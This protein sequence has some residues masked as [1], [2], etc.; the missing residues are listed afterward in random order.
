M[1]GTAVG[2]FIM[3][4][5]ISSYILNSFRFPFL[6]SLSKSFQKY[7]FNN[8]IIPTVFVAVYLFEIIYFQYFSQFKSILE[9]SINIFGFLSGIAM[10]ITFTLRY[11]LLTNKDIYKLFGVEHADALHLKEAEVEFKKPKPRR[12]KK[13]QNLKIWRVDTYMVMPFQ[14]R[15]VRSTEHYKEYMLQ[16]VFKQNH[17]NAA[18]M[19]L[20]VFSVFILLGLFREYGIFQIPA[21]ASLLLLFTI[22]IMLSG[23]FRFWLKS[24]ASTAII[25][26][27]LVL[28]YF[29]QFE[30]FNQ[31][32]KAIGL[33]YSP[34]KKEYTFTSLE[35]A[36]DP[37]LVVK[38]KRNTIAIL[39][40][41]KQKWQEK[42]VDKPK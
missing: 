2:V 8:F 16:S 30:F 12:R 38:D 18:V 3:A 32:N 22:F 27:F 13:H 26:L 7:T 37:Y 31:R 35:K 39:E 34:P 11:F 15:L 24:W 29:S 40:K 41:W 42:G 33:D 20:I 6:A 17:I 9:I 4:F 28:N 1:V 10:V 25:A 21:A 14:T 23:V 36:N 19:E 5:N